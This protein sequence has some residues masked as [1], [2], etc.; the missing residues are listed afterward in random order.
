[1]GRMIE[2]TCEAVLLRAIRGSLQTAVLRQ[3]A[4]LPDVMNRAPTSLLILL[5]RPES[6]NYDDVAG[7][8]CS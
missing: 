8:M 4:L 5:M 3:P 6:L 1:M 7:E 2:S